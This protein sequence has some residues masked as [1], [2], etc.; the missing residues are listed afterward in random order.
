[1]K[2]QGYKTAVIA[3]KLGIS[4]GTVRRWANKG[5]IP[6]PAMTAARSRRWAVRE[7][8]AAMQAAR[9]SAA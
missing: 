3:E 2:R 1:M 9:T 8:L 4:T 5:L 6:S 7:V